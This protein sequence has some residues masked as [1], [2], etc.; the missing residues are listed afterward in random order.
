MRDFALIAFKIR[1]YRFQWPADLCSTWAF[2][3][4]NII[5]G[6]YILVETGSV[7]MLTLFAALQFMGTLVAP[8]LGVLGDRVG[9]K[10]VFCTMRIIFA[11][12][13]F[14]GSGALPSTS[15]LSVETHPV[16][17]APRNVA[18]YEVGDCICLLDDPHPNLGKGV[19]V[20]DRSRE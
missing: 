11:L 18:V 9:R 3:M 1:S 2:E 7:L 6:W 4:E 16:T 8:W 10:I 14:N 12:L 13:A 5:L 20:E 17:A 19:G 15:V